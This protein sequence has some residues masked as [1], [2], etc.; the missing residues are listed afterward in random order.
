MFTWNPQDV[1]NN[2]HYHCINRGIN[3]DKKQLG[4]VIIHNLQF[5]NYV[6]ITFQAYKWI[7]G[8]LY[9][10]KLFYVLDTTRIC[11]I[12]LRLTVHRIFIFIVSIISWNYCKMSTNIIKF[13]YWRICIR[14]HIPLNLLIKRFFTKKK[15]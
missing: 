9:F 12:L 5:L 7:C 13:A 11:K 2:Q 1:T 4:I 8:P 15:K 10:I 14:M 6:H 3:T